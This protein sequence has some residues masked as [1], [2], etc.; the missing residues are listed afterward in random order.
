MIKMFKKSISLFVTAMFILSLLPGSVL[1]AGGYNVWAG[2]AT[3]VNISLP[4]TGD[5]T[6][7]ARMMNPSATNPVV[8]GVTVDSSAMPVLEYVQGINGKLSEDEVYKTHDL[9]ART[10]ITPDTTGDFY[11]NGLNTNRKDR[12]MEFSFSYEQY[13]YNPVS[14]KYANGILFE[15]YFDC[16]SDFA[17]STR[18]RPVNPMVIRNNSIKFTPTLKGDVT[19]AE[20]NCESFNFEPNKWYTVTLVFDME[21][22]KTETDTNVGSYTHKA[23]VNGELVATYTSTTALFGVRYLRILPEFDS[24]MYVDNINYY[25]IEDAAAFVCKDT[26][27]ELVS[28][29]DEIVISDNKIKLDGFST[30][31]EVKDAISA[32][33]KENETAR[34]YNSDYTQELEADSSAIGAELVVAGSRTFDTTST[35]END[36]AERETIYTYYDIDLDGYAFKDPEIIINNTKANGKVKLYNHS[37]EKQEFNIYLAVY[38]NGE[39]VALNASNNELVAE[40][41]DTLVEHTTPEVDLSAG[42]LVKLFVWNTDGIVPELDVTEKAYTIADE[43]NPKNADLESVTLPKVAYNANHNQVATLYPAFDKDVTEYTVFSYSNAYAGG[44]VI[45]ET[46][47]SDAT[48]TLTTE[49]D[50]SLS[51]TSAVYTV[52]SADGSVTK[53][54]TFNYVASNDGAKRTLITNAANIYTRTSGTCLAEWNGKTFTSGSS[55]YLQD[56]IFV[57]SATDKRTIK[58]SCAIIEVDIS[59]VP[60]DI[61]Y[62]ILRLAQTGTFNA[63]KDGLVTL[64][65]I[66]DSIYNSA[67]LSTITTSN[68]ATYLKDEL[69]TLTVSKKTGNN[70]DM[71]FANIGNEYIKALKA[72]GRTKMYIGITGE[73]TDPENGFSAQ[74]SGITSDSTKYSESVFDYVAN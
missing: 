41:D 50:T 48:V 72:A 28:A 74:F 70:A 67:D 37:G 64:Y 47:N 63:A 49:P 62:G 33:L 73:T 30:A 53:D 35:K 11:V 9:D 69:C 23:Y 57:R 1:A 40:A 34:I 54:Y 13:G 6:P 15:S 66:D 24:I 38:N 5:D 59:T 27:A 22:K 18:N 21:N 68:I 16:Y 26:A 43:Y 14:P 3:T 36:L 32:S 8:K 55:L 20:D 42:N 60:E 17:L 71:Y 31:A 65:E 52:T 29:N 12:V 2:D 45:F 19:N 61:A 25:E 44:E 56:G 51:S 10:T 39:L 58:T 4:N 46:V 7:F